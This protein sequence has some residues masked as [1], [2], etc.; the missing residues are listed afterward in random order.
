MTTLTIEVDEPLYRRLEER[1]QAQH[2][3]AGEVARDIL[4]GRE[5]VPVS[6]SE[7]KRS[8]FDLQPFSVGRVLKPLTSEDDLLEEMLHDRPF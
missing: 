1:A 8:V 7:T 6:S 3:T 5:S 2:R 4:L